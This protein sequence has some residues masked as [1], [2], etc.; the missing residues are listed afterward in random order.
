MPHSRTGRM[1]FECLEDLE[2][3]FASRGELAMVPA[4]PGDLWER[5][6][7]ER[8][9]AHRRSFP[10]PRGPLPCPPNSVKIEFCPPSRRHK[11]YVLTSIEQFHTR[12]PARRNP[13]KRGSSS[14][15][16]MHWEELL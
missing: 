2:R 9:N 1:Q 16:P 5:L 13:V 3:Y 10:V 8:R 11:H 4:P 6:D 7:Q 12:L 14:P 15:S